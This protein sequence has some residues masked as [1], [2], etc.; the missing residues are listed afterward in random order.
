MAAVRG[1]VESREVVLAARAALQDAEQEVSRKY[2]DALSSGW[3][4]ADLRGFGLADVAPLGGRS[5]KRA[6]R[7]RATRATTEA[8]AE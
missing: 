4:D 3:T 2:A 1:L 5:V 8:P 7:A 6:P